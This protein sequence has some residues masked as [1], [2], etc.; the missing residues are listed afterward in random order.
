MGRLLVASHDLREYRFHVN[1]LHASR[2][3]SSRV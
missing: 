1:R 3:N 2:P